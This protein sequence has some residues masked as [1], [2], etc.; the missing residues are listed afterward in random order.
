MG[1]TPLAGVMMG[2]RS[3]DVDPAILPYLAKQTG[4][5]MDELDIMLNR[6]SGLLGICGMND[7]RDLHA[8][9]T[10]GNAKAQL[11]FEMFCHSIRKYIG[12]YYAVLGRVDALIFTAG[13]GENDD[14]ARAA[15][16]ENL[17]DLGITIDPALNAV[18]SVEARAISRENGKVRVLVIPT[19]EELAIAESTM[20]VLEL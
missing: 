17:E 20:K 6:K 18:R 2:T 4:M 1:L 19:N 8:A 12:A 5:T 11:A 13:I 9:H 14:L 15:I 3:G 7:M 10:N 16:C